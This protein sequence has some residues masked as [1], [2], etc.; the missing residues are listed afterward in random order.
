MSITMKK[1]FEQFQPEVSEHVR[2]KVEELDRLGYLQR[3]QYEYRFNLHQKENLRLNLPTKDGRECLRA[4]V[5]A[6]FM[7]ISH[8]IYLSNKCTSNAE[9]FQHT[10]YQSIYNTQKITLIEKYNSIYDDK[11]KFLKDNFIEKGGDNRR[12]IKITDNN[13]DKI[14]D[15]ILKIMPPLSEKYKEML[16]KHK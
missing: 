14:V 6:H 5:Y 7:F 15:D 4:Y 1:A 9:A 2:E 13:V 3:Q 11:D 10:G 8:N 12:G 16:S